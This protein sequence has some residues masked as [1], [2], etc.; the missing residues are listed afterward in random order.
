MFHSDV[1][2]V[3]FGFDVEE[4]KEELENGWLKVDISLDGFDKEL[5]DWF[6]HHL[7]DLIE[8]VEEEDDDDE[9]DLFED[10]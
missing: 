10:Y 5:D 9:D 2:F 8:E 7:D 3:D 6:E 4:V 1:P